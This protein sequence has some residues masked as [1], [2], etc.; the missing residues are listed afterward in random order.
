[1]G[2]NGREGS[3]AGV[4]PD[5]MEK[6]MGPYVVA[7]ENGTYPSDVVTSVVHVAYDR[8]RNQSKYQRFVERS[9]FQPVEVDLLPEGTK[10]VMA[11][12]AS[13]QAIEAAKTGAKERGMLPQTEP[14]SPSLAPKTLK[15]RPA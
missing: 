13:D 1:M 15:P 5:N 9:S 11:G 14:A 8:G 2:R 4:D 6:W 12:A 10:L 3:P 7:E